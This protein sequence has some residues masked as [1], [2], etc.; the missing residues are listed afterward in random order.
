[1]RTKLLKIIADTEEF[2]NKLNEIKNNE[3]YS[4]MLKE[5]KIQKLE[6]EFKNNTD[7]VFENLSNSL[8]KEAASI[9]DKLQEMQSGNY[10]KRQYE[11]N[12]AVNEL[13]NYDDI[14]SYLSDKL[15]STSDEIARQEARKAALGKAKANDPAEYEQLKQV[16]ADNMSDDERALRKDLAK[17]DIKRQNLE[18]AKSSFSHDLKNNDINLMKK[19]VIGFADDS[20]IDEKA[21]KKV[22]DTITE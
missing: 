16:V 5:E 9:K 21:A 18:G 6:E 15:N 10:D 14:N 3:L 2:K 20:G 22:A 11:Y 4:E 17:V 13:S 19:T 12:K 8:D 1:M 7:S